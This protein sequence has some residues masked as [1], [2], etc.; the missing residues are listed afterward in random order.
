MRGQQTVKRMAIAVVLAAAGSGCTGNQAQLEQTNQGLTERLNRTR[1]ELDA[2]N[3]RF[4]DCTRRLTA[5]QAEA[6]SL[7]SQLASKPAVEEEPV[8]P[9]WTAVPGGA[10]IA[11]EDTILFAPGK[12]TLRDE[13]RRTLDSIV[14]TV[15]GQY[16]DKDVLVFGHTDDQPIKKS[17][18]D[19]NY[20]LST[21]RALAVVRY[22]K[23]HAVKPSRLVACGAG[24]FRPRVPNSSAANRASNRRVEIYAVDRDLMHGR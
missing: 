15:Q 7:R 8:A 3:R 16:E 1:G 24:E 12:V 21:E 17:G 23:E 18:W 20:Q 11:I 14:S 19:D 2:A 6:S 9:G 22:L 5:A 4:D 10:M 13:A